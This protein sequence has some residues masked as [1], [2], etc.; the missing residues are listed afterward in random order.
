M[1]TKNL[2]L[3]LLC[4]FSCIRIQAQEIVSDPAL[5]AT[6]AASAVA[7][8][9]AY[10]KIQE[11]QTEN[12]V[13]LIAAGTLQTSI[14]QIKQTTLTA[15]Q[16]IQTI[17]QGISAGEQAMQAFSNSINTAGE[18]WNL[19]SDDPTLVLAAQDLYFKVYEET[20]ETAT[21]IANIA[22]N[23]QQ[24]ELNLLN[25]AERLQIITYVKRQ[26]FKIQ[27]LMNQM[28]YRMKAAKKYGLFRILCP[29]EF[30]YARNC[31]Q[32]ATRIINN[33]HF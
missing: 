9:I 18:I 22:M 30:Y 6:I 15:L 28:Y 12:N 31:N 29:R 14:L 11:Q 5:S 10:N 2:T 20:I 26:A 19:V 8:G 13:A 33:F 17:L 25:N 7:D 1:K 24:S 3:I 23:E 4:C 27:G 16:Q 21:Y 32:I